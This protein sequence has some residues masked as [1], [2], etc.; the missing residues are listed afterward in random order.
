MSFPAACQR[1]LTAVIVSLGITA[2]FAAAAP[3]AMAHPLGNLT[4]NTS[5][6][7]MTTPE[8]ID[9]TVVLDFAELPAVQALQD[10]DPDDNGLTDAERSV[11]ADEQCAAL[12][13]GLALRINDKSTPWTVISARFAV[14]DGQAGLPTIRVECALTTP[15]DQ[16]VRHS[17]V[18]LEDTNHADRLGWRE[19]YVSGDGV[20]IGS[21]TG[22]S[23]ASTTALLTH[24]PASGS[25]RQTRLTFDAERAA[26]GAPAATVDSDPASTADTSR[27]GDPAVGPN[28]VRGGVDG[29][30]ARFNDLLAHRALTMPLALLCSA[31]AFLL[32]AIHSLAPGHGKTMMAAAVV[33]ER[34][35]PRQIL[36]IGATVA[37]THT[38]GVVTIGTAIWTSDAIAPDRL[39]P[40]LTVA[41]GSLVL[42]VGVS[43]LTRHLASGPTG[44]H[45]HGVFG[46]GHD[47]HGDAHDEHP[48]DEHR[49]GNE[50]E[51]VSSRWVVVMGLAGGLV[52][53]P[54]A[55]VVLL[56]AMALHRAWFG[57]ALVAVYGIGMA[58]TLLVAGLMMVRLR[59]MVERHWFR[60]RWLQVATRF[61]PLVTATALSGAG[62]LVISRGAAAM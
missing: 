61:G 18:T 38:I 62:V 32:G 12:A 11:A 56:G 3:R 34:G 40:W 55:L 50:T 60:T 9:A 14:L 37:V 7:L 58:T 27:A 2:A 1:F 46:H 31:L 6:G 25:L 10:L 30:T 45:H 43:L 28:R 21:L 36:G 51:P 13:D 15:V 19:M 57:I 33:S 16:A 48:H 22:A 49:H 23:T 54:S 52:P 17:T 4:I 35:T 20:T 29:L 59:S 53:T 44:H 24:Y 42:G 41:S 5:T 8:A 47:H 39:L 26:D